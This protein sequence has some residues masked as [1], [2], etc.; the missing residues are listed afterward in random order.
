LVSKASRARGLPRALADLLR[1]SPAR[2]AWTAGHGL[3]ILAI[4]AATP[5]AFLEWR[6]LGL[7]V[8]SLVLLEDLRPDEG[9]H[10]V[11]ET[12][13]RPAQAAALD[14]VLGLVLRLHRCGVDHGDLK[15]SHVLLRTA[16]GRFEPRLIDLE[17]VRF[18]RVLSARQRVRAL[19]QL[20]ASVG[21]GLDGAARCRFFARYAQALP[22][23]A[24]SRAA[25]RDTAQESLA[26]R[27][28]WSGRGCED[29]RPALAER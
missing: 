3:Q 2:R 9:A 14:A 10:R 19:A 12:S 5:V 26:R 21:D 22:F 24:G 8:R 25:R 15:A 6:R 18:Q 17:G 28:R 13:P 27:H 11:L 29:V 20:N 1:G 23:A 16:G 7:P 4:G